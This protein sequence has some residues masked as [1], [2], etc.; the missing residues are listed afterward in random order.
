MFEILE[1]AGGEVKLKDEIVGVVGD[2]VTSLSEPFLLGFKSR[3][4][5]GGVKESEKT[6]EERKLK[7]EFGVNGLLSHDS[8]SKELL[9]S[10]QEGSRVR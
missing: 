1:R 10:S 6:F 5:A 8:E 9:L 4:T 7:A 3:F 2:E